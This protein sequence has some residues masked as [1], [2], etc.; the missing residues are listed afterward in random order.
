MEVKTKINDCFFRLND[1]SKTSCGTQQKCLSRWNTKT[2]L[3]NDSSARCS[4][5]S[6]LLQLPSKIMKSC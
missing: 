5:S 1:P 3:M 2:T 6:S 4:A